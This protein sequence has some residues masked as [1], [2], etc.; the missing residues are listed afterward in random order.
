MST[1]VTVAEL[2]AILSRLTQDAKVW[3]EA[4][5]GTHHCEGANLDGDRVYIEIG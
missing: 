2:I 4:D 5:Y 3:V 1:Q